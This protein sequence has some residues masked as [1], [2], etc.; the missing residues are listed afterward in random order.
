MTTDNL[1]SQNDP[2]PTTFGQATTVQTRP[3]APAAEDPFMGVQSVTFVDMTTQ[4]VP[5]IEPPS[6]MAADQD[7][8]VLPGT[9]NAKSV[10]D[11]TQRLKETVKADGSVHLPGTLD[12]AAVNRVGTAGLQF[13]A[14]LARQVHQSG[15]TF[16][17]LN[18]SEALQT[19]IQDAGL[20]PFLSAWEAKA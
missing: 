8:L 3:A 20:D 4:P 9:L 10:S 2:G 6:Q 19:A 14:V 16:R 13:I 7:T 17:L 15:G 18:P 1:S 12:G 11:V 5:P